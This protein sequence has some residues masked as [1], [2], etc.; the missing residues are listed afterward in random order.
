MWK[1][2]FYRKTNNMLVT[3]ETWLELRGHGFIKHIL[4]HNSAEDGRERGREKE[5]REEKRRGLRSCDEKSVVG[6]V[7]L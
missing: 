6:V 1:G 3:W 7:Y 2:E 5:R 4:S